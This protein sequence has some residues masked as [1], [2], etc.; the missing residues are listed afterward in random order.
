MGGHVARERESGV[1]GDD[2]V[3]GPVPPAEVGRAYDSGLSLRGCAF[4]LGITRA[5]VERALRETGT[6]MRPPGRRRQPMSLS[7]AVQI[8]TAYDSGLTKEQTAGK[9]GCGL[10]T[11]V[12]G[13]RLAGGTMRPPGPVPRDGR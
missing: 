3:T 13:V 9:I 6:V 11:V 1:G 5:M 4:H 7:Y 2:G 8:R 10:K 12:Q